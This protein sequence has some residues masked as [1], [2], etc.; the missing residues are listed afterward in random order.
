MEIQ[1][2][3]LQELP[4]FG[5]AAGPDPESA[6]FAVVIPLIRRGGETFVLFEKRAEDLD[7]QPGE[8][9]LPG[10][11]AEEREALA[12]TAVRE[13]SEELLVRQEQVKLLG[14]MKTLRTGY[15]NEIAVF[16]GELED[17]QGTWSKDEVA[18]TFEVPLKFFLENEPA[19]YGTA[20]RIEPD[21]DFPLDKIPGGADYPWHARRERVA[22]Y[23][24]EDWVIWG[25][26]ARIM[27]EA[28]RVLRAVPAAARAAGC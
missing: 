23:Y 28:V 19:E 1:R 15:G 2:T 17:Y 26:T 12:Q 22:F 16:L 27:K 3:F 20:A 14:R 6:Q 24:Y 11:A 7:R 4:D 13:A 25:L 9:C 10:G 21:P 5:A 8:I 18:C